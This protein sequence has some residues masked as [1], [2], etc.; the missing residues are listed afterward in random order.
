MS[1]LDKPSCKVTA[2]PHHHRAL[3]AK[4]RCFLQKKGG[5]LSSR[6]LILNGFCFGLAAPTWRSAQAGWAREFSSVRC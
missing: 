6:A 5:N 1:L 2:C 3:Q 4:E